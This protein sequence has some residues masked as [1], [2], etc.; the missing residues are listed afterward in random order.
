MIS[1]I[2]CLGGIG[3]LAGVSLGIVTQIYHQNVDPRVAKIINV[4][5]GYNDGACGYPGCAAYAKAVA[6]GRSGPNLCA[7]GGAATAIKIAGIMELEIQVIQQRQIAVVLCQGDRVKSKTKYHYLGIP[8]CR[9]A[10]MIA[11]GPKECSAGCLGMGSCARNCPFGAIEVTTQGLAVVSREKC[12]GCQKCLSVCPRSVIHM[13]PECATIHV[14]CNSQDPGA[15]VR[16]YCQVGCIA[17]ATCQKVAA[18]AYQIKD[19]LAR[20]N[21]ENYGQATPAITKCPTK[22][23]WNFANGYPGG[24]KFTSPTDSAAAQIGGCVAR[25]E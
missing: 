10:Q 8:D 6:A 14:L 20:V 4:L 21:Y 16:S 25:R 15:K 22:C 9:A 17:C 12:T 3:L 18:E 2:F 7:V 19:N 1:A 23:I 13:A 24:S 11:E 5:P